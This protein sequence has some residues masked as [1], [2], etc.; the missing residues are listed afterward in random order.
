MS[1]HRTSTST[2]QQR[3]DFHALFAVAALFGSACA[4]AQPTE[5]AQTIVI[6][7]AGPERTLATAPASV[8]VITRAQLEAMQ[9][10]S[11]ADALRGLQGVNTSP[12]DARDGKTGNQSISLRGLPREYT[13]V[14][15]DGVRQN[16]VGTVTPNSF[17]DSQSVFIPPVAAIE[18]I[19]VI[20]GP[21]STLYGSDAL[22]GVVNIITRKAAAG[23]GGT[24]SIGHTLQSG[25]EFGDKTTAELYLNV[26]LAPEVASLQLFGKAYRRQD[27]NVQI[28]GVASPRPITA[29]TPTMGQNPVQAETATAG[30]KLRLHAN[31]VHE[32]GLDFNATR[33][34]YD[35]RDG[36]I[37][38]LHRTGAPNNSRCNSTPAPNFCRG[39]ETELQFNRLQA[40]LSHTGRYGFGTWQTRYTRDVLETKGRTL[41]LGSGLA[42][43]L[44]GLPRTLELDTDLF[45][46]RLVSSLGS[47]VFTVGAQHL[48]A[49]LTD[50]LWGGA[51]NSLR[52]SSVYAE[53]EWTVLPG[54]ALTTGLRYDDNQA[55]GGQWTPRVHLVWQASPAWTLKAGVG[56]GYR[57]P[58]LEQLTSGII[59]FGNQ[60]AVPIFGNPT[61]QPEESTNVEF[62]VL[63]QGSDG[64]RA[65][66]TVFRNALSNLIEA[67]TG[68]NAGRAL[69]IGKAVVQGLELGLSLPLAPD[70][71][72]AANY[73]YTDNQVRSTQ[74]DTGS[75]AQLIASK[76][77]DPFGSVPEHQANATLD[78]QAT[79]RLGTFLTAEYRSDAFRPRNFHEPQFG[80]N[81]QG[82]VASGVRDSNVVLGDFKGYSLVH[83]GARFALTSNLTLQAT[84]YNLLDK[85]FKQYR[86]YARCNNAGCTTAVAASSNAYNNILEPR[87][88]WLSMNASF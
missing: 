80:G 33:Q 60:G 68:A 42:P 74:L 41:P 48:G 27:S 22:G 88:L 5:T 55:F 17:N 8:S 81:A 77:G 30:A 82:Q 69:N 35:N 51:R 10:T 29:D 53:N 34:T 73:S 76:V 15:I 75:P 3:A 65:Q 86:D 36:D 78:W 62:G 49:T 79:P 9:V 56:Q 50:G 21:M 66:A 38:A 52:Q 61:L 20:R 58:L 14:L 26:P 24:A 11:L 47:H 87:R 71:K 44:E 46:T 57:T 2:P 37:G 39:Y 54:L 16:P 7:A 4:F 45:D 6:T 70:L 31:E 85:D 59:G 67:G 1:P 72:L 32:L 23:F 63:Y 13:L 19:E 64:L 40:T 83:L 25:S 12:L 84:I 28:P 18:R 43:S